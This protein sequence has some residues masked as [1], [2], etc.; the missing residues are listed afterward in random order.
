M[1][2][3]IRRTLGQLLVL[4]VIGFLFVSAP[5]AVA[6][7]QSTLEKIKNSGKLV[8]GVRFD[9]PPVGT[10]DMAGKPVGF[11]PDIAKLLADA[12]GVKV[13]YQQITSKTRIPLLT[14]GNVDALFD[15]M[16][17][18]KKRDEVVDFVTVYVWDTGVLI[19]PKGESQNI[20]DY[21]PPKKIATTQGSLFIKLVK[22]Q[23]PNADLVLFQEYPDAVVALLNHKVNAIAINR[24]VA[25]TFVKAN[26]QLDISEPFFH[27]PWA[28]GVRE[29]DSDWRDFISW[30]LQKMWANGTYKKVFER[31]FGA[32]PTFSMWSQ[33]R[34][35]PGIVE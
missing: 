6:Q 30:E 3:S 22:D 7:Q 24:S 26:P 19:V 25:G 32:K 31:H 1:S 18:T 35:Q 2:E 21:G 20:R 17:P 28:I 29:N 8:A 13:E 9:Y 4:A 10:I 14:N 34:L 11:G 23:L 5:P 33:Y 12:L 15:A 16:T 27:D